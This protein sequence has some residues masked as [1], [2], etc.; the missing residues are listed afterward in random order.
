MLAGVSTLRQSFTDLLLSLR[1]P[2]DE[3]LLELGADGEVL[4]ARLRLV[5][6]CV[7]VLLPAINYA[8]GGGGRETLIG[9][10]GVGLSIILSQVWLGIARRRRRYPW[11]PY[12][13]TAFDVSI[14]TLV[15]FT[16]SIANALS[17]V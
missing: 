2:R 11:L 5:I 16:A 17:A 9:F 6:A 4:L 7:L 8:A 1:E 12:V 3:L 10:I 13:S 15:L 14:V